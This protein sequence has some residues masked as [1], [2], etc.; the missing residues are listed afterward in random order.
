MTGYRRQIECALGAVE[1][2][3]PASFA[4]FGTESRPLPGALRAALP[5][6]AVREHLVGTLERELYRSFY[7][8]GR[9]VPVGPHRSDPAIADPPFVDALSRANTGAGGWE[10]GWRVEAIE[11]ETV[12]VARDGLSVRAR[13]ADCRAASRPPEVGEHVSV[14]R[15]KEL[16]R[17]SPGFYT[18]LGDVERARSSDDVELRVYFHVTATGAAP[19]V[20]VCTRLLNDAKVAF[21]LKLVDHPT[22][23]TRCDAAVLYLAA[24]SFE[25][26]RRPLASI[27]ASSEPH[28][29]GR[30]PAFAKA[31]AR[32]VAV[33]EHDVRLGASFGSGRCRLL[34]EGIVAAHDS[35]CVTLGDRVDAVARR[36]AE[37]G[38]DVDAPYLAPGSAHRYEL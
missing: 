30:T 11:R 10:P 9:P 26:V 35:G 8:Q 17:A 14:R 21:D 38:L 5:P 18:A 19:L 7:T 22:G 33:G 12:L 1:V 13:V 24:G 23:Y 20:A 36:F 34:A 32:G 4:W 15:P 3:S 31:I 25:R 16:A 29:R 6:S 27:A 37:R 28:L 2:T